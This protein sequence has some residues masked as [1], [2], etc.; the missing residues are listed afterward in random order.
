MF[1]VQVG[2]GFAIATFFLLAALHIEYS[3]SW[4]SDIQFW[5]PIFSCLALLVALAIHHFE[6]ARS[7]VPSGVLLFYW[8]F[9]VIVHGIQLRQSVSLQDYN[10]RLPKLVTL[11]ILETV[12]IVV[13]V[14]EWLVPKTQ[15]SYS[16]LNDDEY[17][18]PT[19]HATVFSILTFG[20]MTPIMR[21]GYTKYL[22][23]EDL[24][25]LRE[26][27]STT[28]TESKFSEAWAR[29]LQRKTPNLWFALF[30]A[31][32]A[33]FGIGTLFKIVQ[34]ILAFVQPQ[35]LRMLIG[36][37]AS[38]ETETPQ[39][40]IQGFAIAVL[41]F[42]TSTIQT[43]SLHQYFMHAFET[44]MRIKSGLTAAIYRKSTRLS[45]EGRAQKSTGD[46]VNLQAVDTQR[47]QGRQICMSELSERLLTVH[48]LRYHAVWSTSLVRSFP[49][50]P[51]HDF[52]LQPIGTEHVC[53]YWCHVD[54]DSGQWFHR[55][56]H[57]EAPEASD[58]E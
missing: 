5:T 51:L 47:L 48:V 40:A 18:C 19:E 8:L 20:W 41:M 52:A 39:P 57:E 4:G 37:V 42:L 27:D 11:V 15:S 45:N 3:P 50:Y 35:L 33:Q 58:E 24:W 32:G 16:A 46:I 6:H 23:Q 53:W 28:V 34:D 1:A 29:Q 14:L 49:D 54:H 25:D 9:F 36:F 55:Q 30:Q 13:F 56:L 17:E 26:K 7:K 21:R 22:T 12:G 38:Y 31:F 2:V 44:G 43:L 10:H